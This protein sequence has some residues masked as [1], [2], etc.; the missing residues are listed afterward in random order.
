M[1][2]WQTAAA[3]STNSRGVVQEVI[4]HGVMASWLSLAHSSAPASHLNGVWE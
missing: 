3:D 4:G 2:E 1:K